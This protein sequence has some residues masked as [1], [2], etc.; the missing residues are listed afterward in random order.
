[1]AR[2]EGRSVLPANGLGRFRRAKGKV[3]SEGGAVSAMDDQGDR[4]TGPGLVEGHFVVEAVGGFGIA[5]GDDDVFR[6]EAGTVG[7]CAWGD[8]K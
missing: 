4:F 3:D 1:M 5:G 6:A 2:G 7:G 8:L